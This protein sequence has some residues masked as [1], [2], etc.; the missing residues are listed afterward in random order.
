MM[1]ADPR[2]DPAD[3]DQT[4]GNILTRRSIPIA[5]DRKKSTTWAEFIRN[6]MD[7]LWATDFFSTEVWT[8]WV[9]S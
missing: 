3:S 5:P 6:H 9:A 2:S 1:A 4:V 7:V 8:L